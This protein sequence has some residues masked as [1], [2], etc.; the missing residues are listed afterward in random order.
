VDGGNLL[1]EPN[2]AVTDLTV[3]KKN[4]FKSENSLDGFSTAVSSALSAGHDYSG[5]DVAA[6]RFIRGNF[7]VNGKIEPAGW[8][9]GLENI[10]FIY[11][12]MTSKNTVDELEKTFVWKC[13][14]WK[15]SDTEQ[16]PCPGWWKDVDGNVWNNPYQNASL[17]IIDQNYSSPL[18]K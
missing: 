3:F 4:W 14:A 18:Y 6:W 16:V 5:D 11:G 17:V 2:N 15:G 1:I 10:Y 12:K 7:I 13:N 8:Y 9:T